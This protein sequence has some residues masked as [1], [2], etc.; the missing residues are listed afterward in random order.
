MI[1]YF[2]YNP[3]TNQY[4]CNQVI[5]SC[6]RWSTAPRVDQ[7]QSPTPSPRQYYPPPTTPIR[8]RRA[9]ADSGSASAAKSDPTACSCDGPS[10]SGGKPRTRTASTTGRPSTRTTD[11]PTATVRCSP[12]GPGASTI[13][14]S[15]PRQCRTPL[16]TTSTSTRRTSPR[17]MSSSPTT[18]TVFW[19]V[20]RLEDGRLA[21]WG[22]WLVLV[23]VRS[24][25]LMSPPSSWI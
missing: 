10:S 9:W 20:D 6:F 22:I 5:C 7:C 11:H 3:S 2:K 17:R 18:W 21:R 4:K 19:L 25:G 13:P 12:S 24:W 14:D 15:P 1:Q 16:S 8:P 23:A